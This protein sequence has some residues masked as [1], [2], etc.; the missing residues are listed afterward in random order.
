MTG[1]FGLTK[2]CADECS[3]FGRNNLFFINET[4]SFSFLFSRFS[5]NK[6]VVFLLG[7]LFLC[8]VFNAV[9]LSRKY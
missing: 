5:N 3:F 1:G 8:S 4:F 7:R 6:Y 2:L 9:G